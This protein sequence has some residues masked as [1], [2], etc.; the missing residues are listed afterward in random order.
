MK[1]KIVLL[2]AATMLIGMAGCGTKAA[3]D[4][5]QSSTNTSTDTEASAQAGEDTQTQINDLYSQE[6]DVFAGHQE[7]W[8]KVFASMDKNK[9]IAQ[10]ADYADILLSTIEDAKDQFTED[11]MNTLKDDVEKIREIEDKITALE[12]AIGTEDAEESDSAEQLDKFPE[13]SGKDLDGN[14]VDSSIFAK[15]KVT[16]VN[17]WFSGCSP[18]VAELPALNELNESLKE[19]GGAVVGINTETL[20]GNKDAIAEAK[21]ILEKQGAD[22]QNLYFDSDSEAGKYAS[23]IMAFPTTLIVDQDGNIVGEPIMGGLDNEDVMKEVQ[24]TIDEIIEKDQQ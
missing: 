1:K 17:F 16:L 23:G 22:Y 19:K 5:A 11:E 6:N 15:N 8:D 20:D 18:C 14:D 13:F 7:L 2:I 10:D 21:S 9:A 4:N 3:T 12:G 24:K